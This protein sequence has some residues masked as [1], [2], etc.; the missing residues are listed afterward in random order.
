MPTAPEPEP[1][2]QSENRLGDIDTP[3]VSP[4]HTP[5]TT[6][7]GRGISVKDPPFRAKDGVFSGK[8]VRTLIIPKVKDA[9]SLDSGLNPQKNEL[10]EDGK[11]IQSAA[12]KSVDDDHDESTPRKPLK[13]RDDLS[14]I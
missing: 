2:P 6:P 4:A 12:G 10:Y 1:Q 8:D 11:D 13:K 14:W 9:A 5:Q 7:A 3:P